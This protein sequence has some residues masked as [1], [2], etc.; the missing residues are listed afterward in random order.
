[1]VAKAISNNTG[2]SNFKIFPD[3]PTMSTAKQRLN[4]QSK[5]NPVKVIK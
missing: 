1:M 3:A 2:S 4:L 5:K